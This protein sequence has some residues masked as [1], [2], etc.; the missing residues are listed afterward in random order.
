MQQKAKRHTATKNVE[1]ACLRSRFI[2]TEIACFTPLP[3]SS[4]KLTVMKSLLDV[5]ADNVG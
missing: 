3:A 5:K 1:K 2:G 4:T